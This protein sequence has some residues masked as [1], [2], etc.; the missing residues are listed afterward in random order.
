MLTLG[1]N[2]FSNLLLML[3]SYQYLITIIRNFNVDATDETGKT[4]SSSLSLSVLKKE[5][6]LIPIRLFIHS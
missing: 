6:M 4:K 1:N 5:D 3:S 2:F